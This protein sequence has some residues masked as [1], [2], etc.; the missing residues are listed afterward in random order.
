MDATM[1]SSAT[2]PGMANTISPGT[3]AT[4]PSNSSAASRVPV[5]R[6][7]TDLNNLRSRVPAVLGGVVEPG[8]EQM[9]EI[10][11]AA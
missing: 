9:A 8:E 1:A 5:T 3:T 6:L 10:N 11:A 4:P 2:S 7:G